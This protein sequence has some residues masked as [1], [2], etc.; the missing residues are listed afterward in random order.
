MGE[1]AITAEPEESLLYYHFGGLILSFPPIN[2]IF[3]FIRRSRVWNYSRLTCKMHHFAPDLQSISASS[4]QAQWYLF[5]DHL[6]LCM[7]HCADVKRH[8]HWRSGGRI[9]CSGRSES[10]QAR[11]TGCEFTSTEGV[12]LLFQRIWLQREEKR[13]NMLK[14]LCVLNVL[15]LDLVAL[16]GPLPTSQFKWEDDMITWILLIGDTFSSLISAAP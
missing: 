5:N 11:K 8:A 3:H 1:R 13:E 9:H 12:S 10:M 16:L 7:H 15:F 4:Y 6:A 14:L 2:I